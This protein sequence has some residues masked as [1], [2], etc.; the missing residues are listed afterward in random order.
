MQ[1]LTAIQGNIPQFEGVATST[2]CPHFDGRLQL[3]ERNL[4]SRET[5]V[6][7]RPPRA[8]K[9]GEI[10]TWASRQET[11]IGGPLQVPRV[12]GIHTDTQDYSMYVRCSTFGISRCDNEGN[13]RCPS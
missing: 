11:N 4:V 12:I 2:M 6:E 13:G 3:K 8:S 7:G 1:E 5:N 9:A 10:A